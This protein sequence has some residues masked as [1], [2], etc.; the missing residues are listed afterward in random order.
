MKN[1][2]QKDI[3]ILVVGAGTM[4]PGIAQVFATNGYKTTLADIKKEAIEMAKQKIHS[5]LEILAEIGEISRKDAV[6]CWDNLNFTEWPPQKTLDVDLVIEA[7]PEVP[8]LK[9][10]IFKE[11]DKL[12]SNETILSSTTS[13]LN[14]FELAEVSNPERV[15]ITHFNNP[16]HIIP[17]VEVVMGPKTSPK[18]LEKVKNLLIS[19]GKVPVI[20]KQYIPGFLVNRL[21]I[22]LLRE[23]AYIVSKG[24]AT[25]EDVDLAFKL[26][27]GLKAPLEGPL[28]SVD[29]IGWDTARLA[30][31]FLTPYLC[32]ATSI[33]LAE[34]MVSKGF[35]G[36]KV[37]RGLKDYTGKSLL[38][39][40]KTRSLKILK[41][42]KTVKELEG[43][44]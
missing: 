20:L 19:C 37:G 11:L 1:K 25:W 13:A 16:P 44:K 43:F 29:Y 18:T 10:Q 8:D 23:A 39:I 30:L 32:N 7:I 9:S 28:E 2:A 21:N 24:W 17:L 15:I 3:K 22:A 14:I 31:V 4:G 42:L 27:A 33:E 40:E 34:N 35:L 12:C 6:R 41:I 38:E 26:N 36:V 5:N